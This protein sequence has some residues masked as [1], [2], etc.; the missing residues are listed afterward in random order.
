MFKLS[1]C[2]IAYGAKL[3]TGLC[4]FLQRRQNLEKIRVLQG[5]STSSEMSS[6]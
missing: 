3:V 1:T 4:L 6:W 2:D 5:Q